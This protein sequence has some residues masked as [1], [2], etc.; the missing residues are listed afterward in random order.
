MIEAIISIV[1]GLIVLVVS[2]L[3]FKSSKMAPN[4]YLGFRIVPTLISKRVWVKINRLAGYMGVICGLIALTS[5]LIFR[6]YCFVVSISSVILMVAANNIYSRRIVERELGYEV[7]G[8]RPLRKLKTIRISRVF[9]IIPILILALMALMI[10]LCWSKLPTIIAV[11]FSA[12]G[13]PNRFEEKTYFAI[14]FLT[15]AS[16]IIMLIVSLLYSCD[17]LPLI[18]HDSRRVHYIRSLIKVVKLVSVL[19]PSIMLCV[20][21]II[22]TYNI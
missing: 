13:V 22:L 18:E 20:L 7:G 3:S 16:S 14:S 21:T 11:H 19:I 5:P 4:P 12:S 10:A 9:Y 8:E 17:G 2:A 1:V 15:L 6:G